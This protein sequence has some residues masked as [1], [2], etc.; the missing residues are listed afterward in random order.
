[1]SLTRTS[2][3]T[4]RLSSDRASRREIVVI[5]GPGPLIGFRLK[6]TRKVY[7][8]TVRAC[9]ERAVIQAVAAAKAARAAKRKGVR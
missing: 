3:A 9:Y 7:E 4:V 2:K 8:T 1:M 6:G 5:I